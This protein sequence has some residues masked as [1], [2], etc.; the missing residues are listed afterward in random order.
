V[1][2]PMCSTEWSR[3][4]AKGMGCAVGRSGACIGLVVV[5]A[6]DSVRASSC[7]LAVQECIDLVASRTCEGQTE[8]LH[9]VPAVAFVAGVRKEDHTDWI[10]EVAARTAVV[11]AGDIDL[12]ADQME[13]GTGCCRN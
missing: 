3:A 1:F 8:V 9:T 5:A 2:E 11:A 7:L 4:I 12:V 10:A 13:E 6:E